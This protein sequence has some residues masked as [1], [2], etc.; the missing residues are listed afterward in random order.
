MTWDLQKGVLYLAV[1]KK[2]LDL[3]A[4]VEKGILDRSTVNRLMDELIAADKSNGLDSGVMGEPPRAP[5]FSS[6]SSFGRYQHL[7]FLGKGAMAEVYRA[8]DPLLE[9]EVAL[10][11]LRQ[12]AG[13]RHR[14]Q[15]EA[16]AQAHINHPNVCQVHEVG[17]IDGRPFIAMQLLQGRALNELPDD[18]TLEK[19][20]RI[21]KLIA[22]AV[23]AAHRVG[24]IHRDL[25]PSNILVEQTED[26]DWIP[27]VLDFGL[28]REVSAPKMTTAGAVIGTPWYMSPEQARGDAKNLDR[29]S[30]VFSLGVTFYE[31]LA[32]TIPFQG[33]TITDVLV[34]ILQ[35]EPAPIRQLKP[36]VPV[37]LQ[38]ILMKALEKEP[39]RRYDSAR[40]LADD[41]ERFLEGEPILARRITWNYRIRRKIRKHPW[42]SAL[43][44]VALLLILSIGI[45]ALQNYVRLQVRLRMADQFTQTW[46]REINALMRFSFQRP[47]H[48]VQP[49][50]QYI[51][52]RL[53]GLEPRVQQLGRQVG[54][55]LVGPA[56]YVYGSGLM[57][58]H[59]W[60]EARRLLERS[61]YEYGYREPQTSCGLIITNAHIYHLRRKEAELA[62]V[63]SQAI[64]TEFLKKI[65]PYCDALKSSSA[66]EGEYARAWISSFENKP[67]AAIQQTNTLFQQNPQFYEAKF[68]EGEVFLLQGEERRMAGDS[69][70]ALSYYRKAEAAY[71]LASSKG[72]SDSD[73]YESTCLLE[74]R[75]M[76]LTPKD[77]KISED[78]LRSGMQACE[79]ALI[80][81]PTSTTARNLRSALH[82]ESGLPDSF[83]Q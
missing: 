13:M 67:E 34:N 2:L 6:Q 80:A 36:A 69:P 4:L 9:R 47:L 74:L 54:S 62:G 71:H 42:I 83:Q 10:K 52:Q 1:Q 53:S 72:A 35:T 26:G 11:I 49:E 12:D 57:A 30:D 7:K 3:E 78:S 28:A 22:E 38:T 21:F 76:T 51:R 55:V 59:D 40:A 50:R 37:D 15:N 45:F 48:D 29:R 5:E 61:W 17:E 23:H 33:E 77:A 16:K 44:S 41:L 63:S 19:R 14:L 31:V 73:V 43:L 58:A 82:A 79:N 39:D 46:E 20:V 65:A 18:L 70:A 56:Y 60:G 75:I 68:L 24:I 25:K 27:Y 64:Q 81:N 66:P 32:G 8:F